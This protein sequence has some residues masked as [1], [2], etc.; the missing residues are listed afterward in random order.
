MQVHSFNSKRC[1]RRVP[2]RTEYWKERV[3]K[4]NCVNKGRI[5]VYGVLLLQSFTFSAFLLTQSNPRRALK[6]VQEQEETEETEPDVLQRQQ[7]KG[8]KGWKAAGE[9]WFMLGT[10]LKLLVKDK[11]LHSGKVPVNAELRPL[12]REKRGHRY[13]ALEAMNRYDGITFSF[14]TRLEHHATRKLLMW[15]KPLLPPHTGYYSITLTLL[16]TPFFVCLY[17]YYII[18]YYIVVTL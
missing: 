13:G 7:N 14:H 17:Y 3:A 2:V 1:A 5:L 9:G 4:V 16:T 15:L 10:L 12:R 6:S 8:A 11:L 18:L